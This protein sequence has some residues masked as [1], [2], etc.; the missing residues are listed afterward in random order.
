MPVY[1]YECT[2]CGP[3]T[4]F[5]PMADYALPAS[6]DL[7]GAASPRAFLT[8]PA[9]ASMDAGKRK[10]IAIN[11]RAAN[12]PRRSGGSHGPGCG[13]CKPGKPVGQAA[14]AAKSFPGARPWMIS[15]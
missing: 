11:E 1:E 10:S 6:C 12:A 5:R 15:H 4:A 9:L 14:S 8:A 3:F 13:C 2:S 7:C